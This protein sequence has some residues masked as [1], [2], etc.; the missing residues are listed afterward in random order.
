MREHLSAGARPKRLP[1]RWPQASAR[2][3]SW[4]ARARA[5]FRHR[6]CAEGARAGSPRRARVALHERIARRLVAAGDEAVA[7]DAARHLRRAGRDDEAAHQLVRAAAHASRGAA[8]GA[9]A[10][11]LA[12]AA[13]IRPHD[14]S[15]ALALAE[16]LLACGRRAECEASFERACSVLE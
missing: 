6:R 14:A 2:A 16:A 8:P 7:A 4:A 9:G 10:D 11:F 5:I 15:V 3:C 1:R 12:E 13:A